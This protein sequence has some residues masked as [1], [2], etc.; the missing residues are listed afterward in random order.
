[1]ENLLTTGNGKICCLRCTAK[2]VRTG[3]QCG[4][5]ALKASRSQKCEFHGG[6]GSGAKTQEGKARIAA[7]NLKHGRETRR[8]REERSAASARLS[9]LEDAARVLGMAVGPRLRGRKAFG[10]VPVRTLEDVRRM[11]LDDALHSDRGVVG[12]EGNF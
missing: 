12:T 3:L 8:A 6:R 1:M 11:M 4:R 5:P 7:A 9:M 10:Y 2:S